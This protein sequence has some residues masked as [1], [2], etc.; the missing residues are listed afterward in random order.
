MFISWD[1]KGVDLVTY[2]PCAFDGVY[3]F[4]VVNLLKGLLYKDIPKELHVYDTQDK[5][6]STQYDHK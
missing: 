2:W 4:D 1:Y 6:T 3:D 5:I